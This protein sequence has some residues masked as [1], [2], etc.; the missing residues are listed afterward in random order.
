MKTCFADNFNTG[1]LLFNSQTFNYV[2]LIKQN[3]EIYSIFSVN[4]SN[5]RNFSVLAIS[6]I[7]ILT[8][9]T[10]SADILNI[11]ELKIKGS[12]GLTFQ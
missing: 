2:G 1:Q 7:E 4:E 12:L 5:L 9:K 10:C 6:K 11:G 8:I 3:M